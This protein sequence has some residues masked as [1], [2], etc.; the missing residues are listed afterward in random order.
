[1]TWIQSSE[2]ESLGFGVPQVFKSLR[3]QLLDLLMR[4]WGVLP[5]TDSRR[6]RG[7]GAETG[8]RTEAGYGDIELSWKMLVSL[9]LIDENSGL[10]A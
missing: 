2:S 7:P 5:E 3:S 1:M 9:R 6:G 4:K 10:G 8:P